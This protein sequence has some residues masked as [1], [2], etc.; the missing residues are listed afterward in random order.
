MRYNFTRHNTPVPHTHTHTKRER[1]DEVINTTRGGKEQQVPRGR[2]RPFINGQIST[3]VSISIQAIHISY[4]D[5]VDNSYVLYPEQKA[6][7]LS[8]NVNIVWPLRLLRSLWCLD[9]LT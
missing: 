8:F 6:Q 7:S 1:L 9:G 4:P 3:H 5:S 2:P